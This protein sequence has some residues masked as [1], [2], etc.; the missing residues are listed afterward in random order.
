M[1]DK[2]L[3]QQLDS[4]FVTLNQKVEAAANNHDNVMNDRRR[5]IQLENQTF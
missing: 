3:S 1:A 4:A 2:A 5:E